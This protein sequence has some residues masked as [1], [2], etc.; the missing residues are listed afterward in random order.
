[1]LFLD[2]LGLRMMRERDNAEVS[3]ANQDPSEKKLLTALRNWAGKGKEALSVSEIGRE[4]GKAVYM[5]AGSC[6]EERVMLVGPGSSDCI[7]RNGWG[8]EVIQKDRWGARYV[9]L[10]VKAVLDGRIPE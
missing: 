10:M 2:L 8:N 1:M 6:V 7:R 3:Y 5:D 4:V 9:C